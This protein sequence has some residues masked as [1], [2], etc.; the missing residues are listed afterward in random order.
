MDRPRDPRHVPKSVAWP[1]AVGHHLAVPPDA[2]RVHAAEPTDALA[3]GLVHV[4]SWQAAY[5]GRFPQDY[6][7]ALDA[8]R[9]GEG[10]RRYLEA[11]PPEG[12]ALLVVDL[13]DRVVGFANV[14]PSRDDDAGGGGELRAIYLLPERWG[15]GDG[16]ALLAAATRALHAHGFGHATLWVLDGNE[17]ARRFYETAGWAPDGATKRDVSFGF[18]IA[19]VR[20]HRP[21]S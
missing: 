20:Y 4:R 19:E 18:P 13:D 7:D 21:L 3:I 11:G 12:E 9:R 8:D 14:G 2:R 17:R 10:W 16:R 6:L 1:G 15:L 5:R